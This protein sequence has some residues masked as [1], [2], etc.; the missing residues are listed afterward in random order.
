MRFA[1]PLIAGLLV[2]SGCAATPAPPVPPSPSPSATGERQAVPACPEGTT[3]VSAASGL[4]KALDA[5][6]PGD[7]I[8]LAD[9]RYEGAFEISAS[10]TEDAPIWLCGSGSAVLDGGDPRHGTVLQLTGAAHWNLIGFAV[11]NGQ[12]G[13]MADGI[14]ASVLGGLRVQ[15]IGDEAIHL[16]SGS[17]GNL[18]V[19][20]TISDTGLRK[21]KFGEGIYV[22]SAESNW[23]EISD[24]DPDTSDGNRLIGNTISGTT[25]E[26]IDIK[27]GTTGGLVQ[28]NEF[29]GSAMTGDA[30]SWV[31]V[32]GNDWTIQDN[33]GRTSPGDGFQTHEIVDGWGTGNQFTGNR[34]RVD[35][36]GFGFSLTPQLGN[37]VA[38][39][40]EVSGAEQGDANVDCEG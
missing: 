23:C 24:C 11:E 12:K 33:T 28:G 26:A 31:D 1:P 4:Q 36:P 16:R 35:G 18:V 40:N 20:S 38:C 9:G 39:D 2:L 6:E 5:A 7:V 34:A 19:G 29:D 13:I 8:A 37:V 17:S 3:R 15:H 21:P 14:T 32:K 22:G 30:D 25:A 27:E 10:G